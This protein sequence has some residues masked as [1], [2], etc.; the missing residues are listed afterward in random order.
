M[1]MDHRVTITTRSWGSRLR[2]KDIFT[3]DTGV[4]RC[5]ASNEYKT[6][7][8]SAYLKVAFGKHI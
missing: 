2:I 4:Y 6:D 7:E 3:L 5:E 1:A 8:T